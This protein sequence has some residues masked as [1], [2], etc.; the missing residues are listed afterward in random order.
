MHHI[1]VDVGQSKIT[2][3]VAVGELFVVEAEAVEHGGV[4]VVDVDAVF[5]GLESEVVGG[6]V[7][8]AAFDAS[9]GEYGGETVMVV[10]ASVYFSLVGAGR[11]AID[12]G[13]A[14]KLALTNH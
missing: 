9:T 12:G 11:G 13:R 10:V 8:V 4:E 2:A 6:A 7:D 1:S 14:A 5:D 3:G